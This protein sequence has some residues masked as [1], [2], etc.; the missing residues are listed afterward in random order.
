MDP[1]ETC[2]Q[3]DH[4]T[5]TYTPEEKWKVGQVRGCFKEKANSISTGSVPGG[6]NEKK[7]KPSRAEPVWE[8]GV[9][10]EHRPGGGFVPILNEAGA[11]MP[12]KEYTEKRRDITSKVR[13]LR[14]NTTR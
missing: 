5:G 6:A 11:P 8:K 2:Q 7:G 4:C 1:C 9:A 12:I 3:P 14:R 13:E 10:G